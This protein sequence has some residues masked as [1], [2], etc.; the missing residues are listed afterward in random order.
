MGGWGGHAAR[1]CASLASSA[2]WPPCRPGAPGAAPAAAWTAAPP[3]PRPPLP[4]N[5]PLHARRGGGRGRSRQARRGSCCGRAA[6]CSRRKS[7]TL[8]PCRRCGPAGASASAAAGWAAP[9]T[10]NHAH[11]VVQRP[12]RAQLRLSVQRQLDACNGAG[13][14]CGGS[15]SSRDAASAA[16]LART[17]AMHASPW[18][19]RCSS[20]MPAGA[21]AGP[22][23]APPRR[24]AHRGG[25]AAGG[26]RRRRRAARWWPAAGAAGTPRAPGTAAGRRAP[27]GRRRPGAAAAPPPA[28]RSRP[29]ARPPAPRH[30]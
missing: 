28:A 2:P 20:C 22:G 12:S 30:A 23:L 5:A 11:E 29:A 13:G 7:R 8:W 17:L 10:P 6:G 15:S 3:P 18:P 26:R 4:P 16:G 1:C 9:R 21:A 14:R 25:A 19:R 24:A 27:P